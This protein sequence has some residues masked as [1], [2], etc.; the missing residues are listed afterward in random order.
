MVND[1][2]NE[3]AQKVRKETFES[4]PT[5]NKSNRFMKSSSVCNS[6]KQFAELDSIGLFAL[7]LAMGRERF[8]CSDFDPEVLLGIHRCF[9]TDVRASRASRISHSTFLVC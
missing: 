4:H 8:L 1:R 9:V 7:A 2:S 3:E 5:T 6:A